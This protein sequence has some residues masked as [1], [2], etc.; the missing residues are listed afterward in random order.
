[1]RVLVVCHRLPFPPSR[2]GKIRPFNIIR[3][4]KSQGHSVTVA[5][6]AR[7]DQEAE[8]GQGLR[9]YCDELLYEVIT[10]PVATLKM[11]ARLPTTV[12][13]SMGY[14]HSDKLAAKIRS[15][16]A[17]QEFEFVLVHC[18]SVAPYVVDI[19]HVPK[20]FDLGDV[21]SQKW[22]I[23]S[24]VRGFPLSLGYWLE[25]RKL[26][27]AEKRLARHFDL[28]TCTTRAELDTFDGFST[29][30]PSGWFPNGVDAE[31]FSPTDQPYDPET[32]CFVGRMDYF[33]NQAAMHDFCRH[34]WPLL[35]D[36]RPELKLQIVGADPAKHIK[37]LADLPGVTVTGSVPD[38]RPFVTASVLTVAPLSI[39]RGT[40]NKILESMAMGVPVVSSREAAGGVDALPDRHFLVADSPRQYRDAILRLLENPAE[41]ARLAG[42][43][44]DR[45]ISH[46]DWSHSMEMFDQLVKQCMSLAG[47]SG[48]ERK[49]AMS[50]S[51]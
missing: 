30:T 27:R 19:R 5:S 33:P 41:R 10:E 4:L 22:L 20:I 43:G 37:A 36:R 26:Q 17:R 31:F 8:E 11:L 9:E 50:A 3:H 7:S 14:F 25:G 29:G 48:S 28:C 12:P 32:I 49:D 47:R 45:I 46:H 35:R 2:G 16:H 34:V 23:Y 42:A 39:A 6:L 1:M 21:D 51:V 24:R 44:R 38:V 13:S 18:S 15:A 40:Q